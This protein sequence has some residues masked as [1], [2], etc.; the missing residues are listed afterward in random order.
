MRRNLLLEEG[1]W[2]RGELYVYYY[3]Y[4]GM[5]TMCYPIPS[6]LSSSSLQIGCALLAL[7]WFPSLCTASN[8]HSI[9]GQRKTLV[10]FKASGIT[11][12]Q[13]G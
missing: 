9:C 5:H 6:L 13:A 4:V 8:V 2:E 12:A 7:E 11:F 10:G 3:T 1:E